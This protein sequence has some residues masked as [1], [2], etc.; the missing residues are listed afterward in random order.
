[1]TDLRNR[2]LFALWRITDLAPENVKALVAPK[3]RK[4]VFRSRVHCS[5]LSFALLVYREQLFLLNQNY[6][7]AVHEWLA[8]TIAKGD[9]CID[10]GA[11]IGRT[12]VFMALLAGETGHV[13][14]VEPLP[15]NCALLRRN[16][17]LNGVSGNVGVW[18]ACCAAREGSSQLFVSD[19][20]RV[21]LVRDSQLGTFSARSL[22][23]DNLAL[24]GPRINVIKIDVEGAEREVLAG[25]T[26]LLCA[27]R[28]KIIAEMHP[29]F[30]SGVVEFLAGFG[31]QPFDTAGAP[32]DPAL[33]AERAYNATAGTFHVA[34]IPAAV[35]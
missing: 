14:A 31:Y 6:E 3:L 35:H 25:A 17:A 27:Q 24:H 32:L 18:E 1:M 19:S 9:R 11:H 23:L 13:D 26:E 7:N 8:A 20:F 10:V 28:P 4:A 2:A 34:F 22:S 15:A 30:C 21:S 12:T 5:G 29:P 33:V 16:V